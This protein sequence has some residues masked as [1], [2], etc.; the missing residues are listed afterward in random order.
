MKCIQLSNLTLLPHFFSPGCTFCGIVAGRPD[1]TP[2]NFA[3]FNARGGDGLQ[4]NTHRD[5]YPPRVVVSWCSFFISCFLIVT[6]LTQRLPVRFIPEQDWITAMR[7]DM[8]YHCCFDIPWWILPHASDA[9]WMLNQEPFSFLL[10]P[11]VVSTFGSSTYFFWVQWLVCFTILL[12]W[13]YQCTAAWV[14]AGNIRFVWHASLRF[15][16]TLT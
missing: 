12:P 15:L 13:R 2:H 6:L 8:I 5:S 16:L 1:P 14:P 4:A 9:E 3:I 7:N 10:P 11:R